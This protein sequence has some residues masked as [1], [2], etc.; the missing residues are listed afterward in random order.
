MELTMRNPWIIGGIG[1]VIGVGGTVV[2]NEY[3]MRRKIRRVKRIKNII[4]IE[5]ESA[6]EV[7]ASKVIINT[8]LPI[9]QVAVP[10]GG[11]RG[12]APRKPS[13]IKVGA[14]AVSQ[15]LPPFSCCSNKYAWPCPA[16]DPGVTFDKPTFDL[17]SE[18]KS[19]YIKAERYGGASCSQSCVDALLNLPHYGNSPNVVPCTPQTGACSMGCIDHM[20]DKPDIK[21]Y[22]IHPQLLSNKI[23]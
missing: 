21:D 10:I 14:A 7:P 12:V 3:I 17:D 22:L 13:D 16:S 6:N 2:L 1:L 4:K 5:K 11:E 9:K 23:Q 20:T 19:T 18:L 8:G 15:P